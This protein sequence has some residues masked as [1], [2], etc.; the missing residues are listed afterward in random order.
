MNCHHK[1]APRGSVTG[2]QGIGNKPNYP[3]AYVRS[4]VPKKLCEEIVKSIYTG[5][6]EEEQWIKKS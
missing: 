3:G 1:K 5:L 6:K 2:T 4:V